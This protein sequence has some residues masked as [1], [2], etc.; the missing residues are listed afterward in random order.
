M[1]ADNLKKDPQS[2]DGDANAAKDLRNKTA[3]NPFYI[4]SKSDN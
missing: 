1:N 2:I 4:I 3:G